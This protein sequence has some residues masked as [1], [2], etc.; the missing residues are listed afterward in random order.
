[1]RNVPVILLFLL[2]FVLSAVIRSGTGE[3]RADGQAK[4]LYDTPLGKLYQLD[5]LKGGDLDCIGSRPPHENYASCRCDICKK[6]RIRVT[7]VLTLK[8]P[9]K[10]KITIKTRYIAF[11]FRIRVFPALE[12]NGD[13]RLYFSVLDSESPIPGSMLFDLHGMKEIDEN[14]QSDA[15]VSGQ[16]PWSVP[17]YRHYRLFHHPVFEPLSVRVIYDLKEKKMSY[18]MNGRGFDFPANIHGRLFRLQLRHFGIAFVMTIFKDM[19]EKNKKIKVDRL[20]QTRYFELSSPQVHVYDD[21]EEP[22]PP[23]RFFA[24]PY[25]GYALERSSKHDRGVKASGPLDQ[26]VFKK[27]LRHKNPDLQ[28]AYALRYLYGNKNEADPEKGVELLKQSAKKKHALALYQLG[29]C[30]WRGYGCRPDRKDAV[31]YLD[32][33]AAQGYPEAAAARLQLEMERHGR[34]WFLAE[35]HHEYLKQLQLSGHGHDKYYF[36]NGP[37]FLS[38]KRLWDELP[39]S[40]FYRP[41]NPKL[42][43]LD[44]RIQANDPFSFLAAA[45]VLNKAWK[46]VFFSRGERYLER[47][48]KVKHYEA[49]PFWLLRQ[50]YAD[51]LPEKE[52]I[53]LEMRLLHADNPIFNLVYALL[54]L[55]EPERRKYLGTTCSENE[56]GLG[57]RPFEQWDMKTPESGYLQAM[58]QCM[59]FAYTPN[60]CLMYSILI[61]D[62]D[63]DHKQRQA[64]FEL[65]LASA[66]AGYAPAQYLAGKSFYYIDLPKPWLTGEGKNPA[67]RL[68]TAEKFLTEAAN[69]G[70][71]PAALLLCKLKMNAQFTR[72]PEILPRLEKLCE[73]KIPEAFYLKAQVLLKMNRKQEALTAADNAVKTGEHRGLLFLIRHDDR[74][75]ASAVK[76]ERQVEY[77]RADRGKRRMDPYDPYWDDPL[78]EYMKWISAT[79]MNISTVRLKHTPRILEQQMTEKNRTAAGT[80]GS[81]AVEKPTRSSSKKT[82]SKGRSKIRFR[83]E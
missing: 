39:V 4:A 14:S 57:L 2:P 33:S 35:M 41:E 7:S 1:M 21:G 75:G 34:P 54:C 78:G 76:R 6:G 47:A 82:K 80:T 8:M 13:S 55:P 65:I 16:A 74:P 20:V 79:T 52:K 9:S 70:H 81:M 64:I 37:E 23:P 17:E 38:P 32:Q 48:L 56:T 45:I 60:L 42:N 10:V 68:S 5:S 69:Q 15:Y 22:P 53:P 72:W 3:W 61:V 25:S 36:L 31:R 19:K 67:F 43:Y 28:Y 11:D 30:F 83:D 50:L 44:Y 29:I 12:K 40:R 26:A 46:D 73:L 18:F 62:K 49:Y 27:V 51:R 71:I 77:I 66:R 59:Q 24:Y 58:A 63:K